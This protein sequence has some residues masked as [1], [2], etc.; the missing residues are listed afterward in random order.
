MSMPAYY[1]FLDLE[2]TGL[3]PQKDEILEIG[4]VLVTQDLSRVLVASSELCRPTQQGK[5][6]ITEHVKKLTGYTDAHWEKGTNARTTIKKL[7][8]M[9]CT[10]GKDTVLAGHNIAFDMA[11]MRAAIPESM[12]ATFD[13]I[14]TYCTMHACA[15]DY[16]SGA[17]WSRSLTAVHAYYCGYR[18][19]D[20]H[21]ALAD[22]LASMRV[23]RAQ[24]GRKGHADPL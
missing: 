13:V 21:S 3:D 20:P 7:V 8:K 14:P 10:A 4:Y 2:T 11:F 18:F 15:N 23:A 16:E 5:K 17:L 24:M 1:L 22:A 6:R 19:A 12:H 9:L